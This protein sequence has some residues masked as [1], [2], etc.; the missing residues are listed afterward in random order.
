MTK[1]GVRVRCIVNKQKSLEIKGKI[2]KSIEQRN[3]KENWHNYI[4]VP[5]LI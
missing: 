5:V 1:C 4:I 3:K 2:Q